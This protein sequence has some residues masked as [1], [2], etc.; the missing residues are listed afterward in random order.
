MDEEVVI[1]A[2]AVWDHVAMETE[3]L[4]FRAGD[5]IEVLDT[6]DRD[7]WWGARHDQVGWFPS[8]FVR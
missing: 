1:L 7:W 3:E 6:L 2:E 4:A 5:V 8:A